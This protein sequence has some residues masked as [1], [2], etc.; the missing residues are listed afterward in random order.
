MPKPPSRRSR[1][2]ALRHVLDRGRLV[3]APRARVL[4]KSGFDTRRRPQSTLGPTVAH[5]ARRAPEPDRRAR[6]DG[7]RGNAG[8]GIVEL[9]LYGSAVVAC[10][11]GTPS[12]GFSIRSATAP[13]RRGDCPGPGAGT[14]RYDRRRGESP[15]LRNGIEAGWSRRSR[16]STVR[17]CRGNRR[18]RTPAPDRLC[19]GPRR[20]RRGQESSRFTPNT[21]WTS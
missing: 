9:P 5:G 11:C 10:S 13:P 3:L 8:A 12:G 14:T 19:R 2:A 20:R 18:T 7:R 6:G 21:A 16:R 1:K 4:M 15:D 17:Y